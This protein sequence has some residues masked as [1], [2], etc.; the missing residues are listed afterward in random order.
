MV[1]N[2]DE[3][4]DKW[5]RSDG[6][7][8]SEHDALMLATMRYA[9]RATGDEDSAADVMLL[10]TRK[11]ERFSR[12]G[13]DSY[14]RWVKFLCKR[15]RL[16]RHRS[17]QRSR[18]RYVSLQSHNEEQGESYDIPGAEEDGYSCPSLEQLCPFQREVAG[19]I[20]NGYK[21]TEIATLL[22]IKPEA[23]RQRLH[24]SRKSGSR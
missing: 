22:G 4:Y 16:E 19:Y 6:V 9:R 14:S 2:L 24:R 11:W 17:N 18:S 20:L 13:P 3:L 7:S 21:I 5:W 8:K 10:I 12:R 23:L 15:A 1:H